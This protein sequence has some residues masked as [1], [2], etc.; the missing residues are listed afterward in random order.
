MRIWDKGVAADSNVIEFTS[1]KDR[2]LDE[3]IAVWDIV[4][5]MAHTVML[6][7]SGLLTERDRTILLDALHSLYIDS[8]KGKLK[9][10]AES[11]DIHSFIESSLE[12]MAGE[13]GMKIHAGRSRNDQV[14]CD[15][16][17]YLRD[18][19]YSIA[20]EV[21]GL[22][23]SLI[24]L[25]EKYHNVMMP[26]YTHMQPAMPSSFG[27]WFGSFA[28]SLCDDIE[29]LAYA[30]SV[31]NVNPLGTAAGYGTTLP[32]KREVTTELL[33]FDR[34]IINPA[35]TQLRRGRA[36]KAFA[37]AA[38]SVAFTL[39]R[40]A[41]DICLFMTK[42]FSFISFSDDL[43]T[44]SSIMPQKKNPDVFEI[45]RARG[46]VLR[47]VPNTLSL[48]V[49][50]LPSGYNRDY[51]IIKE[52]LFPVVGEIKSL[53]SITKYMLHG[54]KIREGILDEKKYNSIFSAEAANR[55]VMRGIPFREAYR[56]V[57]SGIEGTLF[58][59]TTPDDY[60]HVGSIGNTCTSEIVSRAEA[61]MKRVVSPSH[62]KLVANII[63][64]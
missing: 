46:N 16:Y 44:G 31:V 8:V 1:G 55:M 53:L 35:Y 29:A 37:D 61:L 25:S 64:Y 6:F 26:G 24:A 43:T 19:I 20:K 62:K 59:K 45:V 7:K 38:G 52:V 28:E 5:S 15:I 60:T 22:L 12:L 11:E 30:S 21:N 4:N 56:T 10:S 32:I 50:N 13:T 54:I 34:L 18:E 57:A 3:R 40:L 51:Q 39:S 41:G 33:Q 17:L 27:L 2:G 58:D 23:I 36:E 14:L 49:T 9:I 47:S 63:A 42:E 48:L